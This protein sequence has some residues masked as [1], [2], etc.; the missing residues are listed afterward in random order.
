MLSPSLQAHYKLFHTTTAKSAPSIAH[1]H[2]LMSV[3]SFR[4]DGTQSGFTCS[5]LPPEYESCQLNPGC[6][7]PN[8]QV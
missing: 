2:P 1:P 4:F 7:V 5:L 3:S 8:N 6:R